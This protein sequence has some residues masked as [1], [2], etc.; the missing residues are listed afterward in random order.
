M[1]EFRRGDCRLITHAAHDTVGVRTVGSRWSA[2]THLAGQLPRISLAFSLGEQSAHAPLSALA[3]FFETHC[4]VLC[5]RTSFGIEGDWAAPSQLEESDCLVLIGDRCTL[6]RDALGRLRDYLTG[7][8][9]IVACRPATAA[10][11][12]SVPFDRQILGGCY[13]GSDQATPIVVDAERSTVFPQL[14]GGFEPFVSLSGLPCQ[15]QLAND[16]TV[17]LRGATPDRRGPVGWCR[18]IGPGRIFCTTLGHGDD[19]ARPMF[20]HLMLRAVRWAVRHFG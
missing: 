11:R 13:F 4:E 8:G 17:L 12:A 18:A 10:F 6:S 15:L 19:F 20:R 7:G 14:T 2:A 1:S 5:C 16:A 3:D 9:A